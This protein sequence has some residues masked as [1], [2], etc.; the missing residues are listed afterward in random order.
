MTTPTTP[1]PPARADLEAY[2]ERL[3][4]HRGRLLDDLAAART[5]LAWSRHE[6]AARR[7]LTA[8]DVR[9]LEAVGI[10][11][12]EP[13]DADDLATITRRSAQIE[14]I[15]ALQAFTADAVQAA[16]RP[17]SAALQEA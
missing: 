1:P 3:E 15:D 12:T 4:R 6:T 5:R 17:R 11:A 13:S 7:A 9:A 16:S 14:A 8:H 2:A 10:L